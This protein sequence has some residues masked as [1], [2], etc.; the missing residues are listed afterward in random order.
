MRYAIIENNKVVNIVLATPEFAQEQGWLE[1][2]DGVDIGWDFDGG[3][4]IPPPR[5]IEAEWAAVRS[6]RDQLLITS[7]VMVLPDRWNAMTQEQQQ[8]W[9]I[10]RQVLRDLPQSFEDPKYVIWPTQPE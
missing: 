10:Y 8:A 3:T 9:S 5:N 1:C 4:P 6:K 7:D 2:P